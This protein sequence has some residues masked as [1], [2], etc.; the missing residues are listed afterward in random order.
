MVHDNM[1]NVRGSH[2]EDV[3]VEVLSSDSHLG[4]RNRGIE[5]PQIPNPIRATVSLKLVRMD[6]EYVIQI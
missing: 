4:L 6:L 3:A 2:L 1:Q 5:Q